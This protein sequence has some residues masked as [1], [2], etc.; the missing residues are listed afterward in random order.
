MPNLIYIPLP[1]ERV[2]GLQRGGPDA[3]GNLPEI[4]VSDG[5]GAPCRHCL[6]DVA[7]GEEYLILSY[8]PFK[9]DQPYAEQGPIFL[10]ARE[11]EAY[12]NPT[13]LPELYRTRTGMLLRGYDRTNR[14][15]YGT[16]QT[17]TPK[18]I[19]DVAARL[20]AREDISFV[21]ARSPTNN[22]FHFRI[23]LGK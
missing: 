17:A 18:E 8:K 12:A 16:G 9:E 6:A 5:N 2:R 11:C 7:K 13:E 3:H 1:T 22:C 21:H 14:I 4:H 15:V 10:H 19:N 20:L 23:E